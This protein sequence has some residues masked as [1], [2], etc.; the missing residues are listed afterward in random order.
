MTW[1]E[2]NISVADLAARA[3]HPQAFY[4]EYHE[5]DLEYIEDRWPTDRGYVCL[6]RSKHD[7]DWVTVRQTPDIGLMK[8]WMDRWSRKPTFDVIAIHQVANRFKALTL[9]RRI[10]GRVAKER[11]NH[12]RR[13][14]EWFKIEME[15]AKAAFEKA[16][17][18]VL[19]YPSDVG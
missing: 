13:V 12:T 17:D 15:D 18:R 9:A 16:A 7:P 4:D 19:P 14:A 10:V 2:L 6:I 3:P 1:K 5:D 8:S 11:K